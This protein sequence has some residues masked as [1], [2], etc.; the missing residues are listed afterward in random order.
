MWRVTQNT[1]QNDLRHVK[2]VMSM[3]IRI[4]LKDIKEKEAREKEEKQK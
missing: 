4:R 2:S 3:I 1:N